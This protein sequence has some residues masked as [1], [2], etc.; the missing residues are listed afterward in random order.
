MRFARELENVVSE[1]RNA[2]NGH[3]FAALADDDG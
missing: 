2:S 1:T 3:F